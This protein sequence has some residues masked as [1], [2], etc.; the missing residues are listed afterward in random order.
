MRRR[1]FITLLGSSAAAWPVLARAQQ[2][3]IPSV[4]FLHSGSPTPAAHLAAAFRDGLATTGF[5]ASQNVTI[6]YRWAEGRYDQLPSLA[7]DL[8]QR[9]VSA[10]I[11]GGGD[12]SALAA[13]AATT[14]TPIVF[15]GSDDPIRFGLV[16][17][18]NRPGGNITGITLFTSE[19]EMKKLELLAELLP[20]S[21]LTGVIINPN[22]A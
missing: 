2:P 14:V 15:V 8:V 9:H 10:L 1:E 11:A 7:S 6:Q 5:I 13:K 19:I 20:Q 16:R 4:G 21:R 18:L 17:A 12:V 3:A 22:N